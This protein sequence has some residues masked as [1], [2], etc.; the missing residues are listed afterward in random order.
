MSL[1]VG[2]LE[3][4]LPV[5]P[6]PGVA[7]PGA[8]GPLDGLP[9][10]VVEVPAGCDGV[11]PAMVELLGLDAGLVLVEGVVLVVPLLVGVHGAATVVV[12][13]DWLLVPNV[14]PVTLPALPAVLGV[15]CV[16]AGVPV[17]LAPGV[18]VVVAGLCVVVVPG[19]VVPGIVDVAPG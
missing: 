14:P 9:A 5:E 13:L 19:V 4:G 17:E 18:V 3:I 6:G 11:L 7:L 8:H 2:G 1:G 12:V 10:T 15:P 16:A